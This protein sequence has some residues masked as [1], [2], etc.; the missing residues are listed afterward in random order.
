M[1][2]ALIAGDEFGGIFN[3]DKV[4]TWIVV[5]DVTTQPGMVKFSRLATGEVASLSEEI[6]RQK[7]VTTPSML[8]KTK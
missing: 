8:R 1:T 6:F 7:I 4:W 2:K 3:D 5:T